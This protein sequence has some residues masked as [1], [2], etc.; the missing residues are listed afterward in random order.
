MSPLEEDSTTVAAAGK[1]L[2]TAIGDVERDIATW[3]AGPRTDVKEYQ[4]MMDRVGELNDQVAM[5]EQDV[6]ELEALELH[7]EGGFIN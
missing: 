7:H 5:Y 4:R 2:E 1:V 3:E 6:V